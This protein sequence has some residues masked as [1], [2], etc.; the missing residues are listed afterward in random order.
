MDPRVL[1]DEAGEHVE[2]GLDQCRE[3]PPALDA[4]HDHVL[5]ADR[6]QH[7][8]VRGVARLAAA[9]AREAELLEEDL[10]ELLGGGDQELLFGE[11]EDLAFEL[12]DLLA[13][14]LRHL[15]QAGHVQAHPGEL[16]RA[17]HP[18]Q[19]QLDVAHQTREA[20][21]R[22]LLALPLR[23]RPEQ[24]RVAGRGVLH[25]GTPDRAPRRA[26]RRG[27][28]GARAPAGR[29]RAGCRGPGPPARARAPSRRG[30]APAALHR[31]PPPLRGPRSRLRVPP[32]SPLHRPL[33][34]ARRE[35]RRPP[36]RSPWAPPPTPARARPRSARGRPPRT[37]RPR[38][39]AWRRP[40]RTNL[41][42]ESRPRQPAI[43]ATSPTVPARTRPEITTSPAAA[44]TAASASPSASSMR[45][46]GSRSSYSRN[47]SRRRER[48][49]SRA[50]S[51]A[52]SRSIGTSRSTV[53]RRLETRAFSAC[54]S[55]FSLRFA[56]LISATWA[57]TSSRRAEALDQLGGG[58]VADPGNPGDVVGG[59]ALEAVEVRDQRGRDPV[60]VE[61]RLVVVEL[62]LGDPPRGGHHLDE[63]ALVDQLE[64]VA[65]A[66]DDH[67]SH[68]GIGGDRARGERGDHVVGLVA[69]DASRCGSR[70]PP[71]AVPSRAT[72]A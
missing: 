65:V 59:V 45:R 71:R 13:H 25:V 31:R 7:A 62:G 15:L 55:R 42:R 22:D 6:L 53:A 30:R 61:H 69:L 64:D 21:L 8:G 12:R 50:T 17:Q 29:R 11:R 51:A 3:L 46:R 19:R 72:A 14:T 27:S 24:Q 41:R 9:L 18:H 70:T 10:P 34:P 54:S 68:R 33:A 26:P 20:P 32:G 58:L 16:H 5:G 35:A 52:G 56:P 39:P 2:V 67:H 49:G 43:A 1:V 28:R 48:S 57:S 36:R 63:P 40:P 38:A 66:G 44:G 60:A 37:T 47:T 4:R 23:E